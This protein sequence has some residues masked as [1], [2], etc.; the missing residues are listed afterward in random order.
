[1][2]NRKSRLGFLHPSPL[3]LPFGLLS[4]WLTSERSSTIQEESMN[5]VILIL[6][7]RLIIPQVHT[8]TGR[9]RSLIGWDHEQLHRYVS[10]FGAIRY[11]PPQLSN[12]AFSFTVRSL[13]GCPVFLHVVY[14]C[15][16]F[17]GWLV[18][19]AS[20]IH[21]YNP[22]T[23]FAYAFASCSMKFGC[24]MNEICLFTSPT[25]F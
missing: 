14:L 7:C 10:T 9:L 1:M 8:E 24:L 13:S 18:G 4:K 16:E 15:F 23:W 21:Y 3:E 2:P 20:W 19:G 17:A 5:S 25:C 6:C 12:Y 11:N 22:L